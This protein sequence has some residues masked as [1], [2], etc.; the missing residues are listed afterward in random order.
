MTDDAASVS[1]L[2]NCSVLLLVDIDDNVLVSIM[3]MREY[4]E[5]T[6]RVV[7]AIQTYL[8]LLL[9]DTA[10]P[11]QKL[12]S[13]ALS[14]SSEPAQ[15][16]NGSGPVVVENMDAIDAFH[17]KKT[18]GPHYLSIPYAIIKEY[19][20]SLQSI[21][22]TRDA[23]INSRN[24]SYLLAFQ[25]CEE[26]IHIA[27]YK[28]NRKYQSIINKKPIYHIS[29]TYTIIYYYYYCS[30]R[31]NQTGKNI[32]TFVYPNRW[33]MSG[34]RVGG[35]WN[36]LLLGRAHADGV[37]RGIYIMDCGYQV[38]HRIVLDQGIIKF[39]DVD[40]AQFKQ[41]MLNM[42]ETYYFYSSDMGGY[43]SRLH[44][45]KHL[46]KNVHTDNQVKDAFSKA[47]DQVRDVA[48]WAR[49]SNTRFETVA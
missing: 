49:S 37:E 36:I 40:Y 34:C 20:G 26:N 18:F 44:T 9:D 17:F 11:K 25:G 10:G 41:D 3:I 31:S 35:M 12:L 4:Q 47:F 33:L 19:F 21:M 29:H 39:V 2:S 1:I 8:L 45:S 43:A 14:V 15:D 24:D 22:E 6:N 28:T 46:M 30:K 32:V 7:L 5:E 13:A 16:P 27:S 38:V 48:F 23:T 42:S